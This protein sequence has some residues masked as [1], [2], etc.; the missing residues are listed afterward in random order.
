MKLN[1]ASEKP[2]RLS[3]PKIHIKYL[4]AILILSSLFDMISDLYW[5]CLIFSQDSTI[6]YV[7]IITEKLVLMILFTDSRNKYFACSEISFIRVSLLQNL[8]RAPFQK[9]PEAGLKNRSKGVKNTFLFKFCRGTSAWV[10]LG[11]VGMRV[12][13]P[14]A[15]SEPTSSTTVYCWNMGMT[16]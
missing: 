1:E 2:K 7:G 11:V 10:W 14:S 5:K 15:R 6:I 13:T 16:Q 8:G 12:S 9:M 3:H 4:I